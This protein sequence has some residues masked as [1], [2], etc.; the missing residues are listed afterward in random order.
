MYSPEMRVDMTQSVR[1]RNYRQSI[2]SCISM[3]LLCSCCAFQAIN[4]YCNGQSDLSFYPSIPKPNFPRVFFK[5]LWE[6]K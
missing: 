2:P 6:R 1:Q 4:S 5:R 3:P